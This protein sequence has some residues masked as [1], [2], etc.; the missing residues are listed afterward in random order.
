MAIIGV[1]RRMRRAGVLQSRYL[2]TDLA[3]LGEGRET[4]VLP[5]FLNLVPASGSESAEYAS[6]IYGRQ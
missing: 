6:M 2:C 5:G 3:R 4:Q 1:G